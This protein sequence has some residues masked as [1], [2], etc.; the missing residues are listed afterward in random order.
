MF[1]PKKYWFFHLNHYICGLFISTNLKKTI[2]L[3]PKITLNLKIES[4]EKFESIYR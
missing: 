4:N 1:T 3:L 2:R